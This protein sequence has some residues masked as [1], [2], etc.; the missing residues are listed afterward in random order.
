M[1]FTLYKGQLSVDVDSIDNS[2]VLHLWELDKSKKKSKALKALLYVFFSE[3]LSS[4]NPLAQIPFYDREEKCLF[5]AFGDV[6][7]DIH[8]ELGEE[9][10]D[11][12]ERA[13]D[14]Y[15]ANNVPDTLKD[16]ATFDRKMDQLGIMLKDTAPVI[17]RN[18]H[19]TTGKITFSANTEIITKALNSVVQ[20]IQSKASV[21]SIHA[22][23][24][25]PRQLRGGL[26]PLSSGKIKI[27]NL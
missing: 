22:Q 14:S 1:K 6:A 17:R 3:D 20:I 11:A 25:I 18:V 13:K 4:D 5:R 24:I 27:D 9:W 19:E 10:A 21:A 8:S 23:G 12:I 7:Y 15:R 2:D 26:S 16:I